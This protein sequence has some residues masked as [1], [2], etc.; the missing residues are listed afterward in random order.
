MPIVCKN[1]TKSYSGK[2]VL[3]R[4]NAT[5]PDRGIT[6]IM[7][8]S[9]IGKTTLFRLLTGLE[10]ADDGQ[11]TG[12]GEKKLSVVFQEDRLFPQLT[13]YE[14]LEI[15]GTKADMWLRKLGL[16]QAARQYPQELSG[17]MKRRVSIG[18]AL[19][20]NGDV[21]L[22]DEP[23]Q[24]LDAATKKNVMDIFLE[25]KAHKTVLF[26]THDQ[27]EADYLADHLLRFQEV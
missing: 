22:L 20:H 12:L 25:K 19:C 26:I 17:G 2:P 18:R 24:G 21:F 3:D 16:W 5:I 7:G 15:V 14:N 1:L 9:G 10:K 8:P 27:R 11:I 23:F 4:W 6:A 13:V